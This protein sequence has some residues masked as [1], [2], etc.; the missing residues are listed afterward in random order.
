MNRLKPQK[1]IKNLMTSCVC[2]GA[3][4]TY[5][6]LKELQKDTPETKQNAFQYSPMFYRSMYFCYDLEISRVMF[7]HTKKAKFWV[8][9]RMGL[10]A[11][12]YV[13]TTTAEVIP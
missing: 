11:T 9:K 2:C 1:V 8:P 4:Y 12:V 3:Q 7:C 10:S 13:L 5:V 6:F